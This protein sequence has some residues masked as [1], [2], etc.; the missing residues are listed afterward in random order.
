MSK[1]LFMTKSVPR[2]QTKTYK[3]D[4]GKSSKKF[5]V[6]KNDDK[7]INDILEIKD[8]NEKQKFF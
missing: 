2:K 6:E 1:Y 8:D 5:Y 4:K 3:N 7:K